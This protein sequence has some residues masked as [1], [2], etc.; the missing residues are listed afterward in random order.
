MNGIDISRYQQGI[1]LAA[2][3]CDFVIVKAS[4]GSSSYVYPTFKEQITQ[5][6]SLGKLL[7]VYHYAST[8]GA[9][10]EAEKFLKTVNKYIG[11]AILCFDWE[12]QDNANFNNPE[13]ALSWLRYVE[14]KTGIKPFIYMSKSVARQY[15]NIWDPSFPFW[16]AQYKKKAP[17]VY[18][19]DPWTDVYGFGPWTDCKILQYS[20]DGRLPGYPKDLDLDKAYISAEEWLNYAQGK[21]PESSAS[22]PKNYPTL[23]KGDK[24]DYVKNWQMFLNLHG[25]SCGNVDGIF[26]AKTEAAVKKWQKDHLNICRTV[27][28]II[29]PR[30]WA[31]LPF[32]N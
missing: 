32:I 1:N 4:Q 23:R 3:P 17:T 27:D 10:A 12:K 30:T 26:G 19:D 18:V 28:G 8:G 29:G 25:Y 14:Q 31:S 21:K 11:K 5:A 20:S 6:E 24:N 2:V 15:K 9:I 13:Y 16:C 7:G 22:D